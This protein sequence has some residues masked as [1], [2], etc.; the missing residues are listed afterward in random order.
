MWL[1]CDLLYLVIYHRII[2]TLYQPTETTV[3]I[4]T[5]VISAPKQG[6]FKSGKIF[7]HPPLAAWVR[8]R[9][10]SDHVKRSNLLTM[11]LPSFFRCLQ[12]SAG[13]TSTAWPLFVLIFVTQMWVNPESPDFIE[14]K[15]IK[16]YSPFNSF[17][18]NCK[19]LNKNIFMNVFINFIF[20]SSYFQGNTILHFF[21]S[22]LAASHRWWSIGFLIILLSKL[23]I[24]LAICFLD[25]W[26]V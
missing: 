3:A 1:R 2:R 23:L 19:L 5:A 18:Q 15:Y 4:Q 14:Y 10:K 11:F 12:G 7:A 20:K 6:G 16:Q 9:E 25:P 13:L 17:F 24:Y 21:N 8:A 22:V 26:V